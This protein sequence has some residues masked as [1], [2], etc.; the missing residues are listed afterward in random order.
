MKEEVRLV[1]KGIFGQEAENWKLH[2]YRICW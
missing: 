1:F 2:N